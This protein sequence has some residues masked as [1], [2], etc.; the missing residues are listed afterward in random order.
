MKSLSVR[1]KSTI[2]SVFI[3]VIIYG[4]LD[5][6]AYPELYTGSTN[7]APAKFE[8]MILGFMLLFIFA[9][10]VYLFLGIPVSY[11]VDYLTGKANIKTIKKIY[12][13]KLVLYLFISL[14]LLL[15]LYNVEF[16]VGLQLIVIP[17][18]I[19]F[20]VLYLLRREFKEKLH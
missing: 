13:F 11:L 8:S 4:V 1:I 10:R 18:L 9:W 20:H 15:L 2:I 5:F 19:W 17:V 14:L 7:M 16:I 12:C 3:L 6:F